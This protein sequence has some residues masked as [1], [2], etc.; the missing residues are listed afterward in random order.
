MKQKLQQYWKDDSGTATIEAVLWVPIFFVIF[1]LIADA[2]FL[3]HHQAN[4][5]RVVHDANRQYSIGRLNTAADAEA[6][7]T[8]R[9]GDAATDPDTVVD[10][11]QS[12]GIIY[13]S[14]QVEVGYFLATG[15]FAP[16]NDV[17]LVVQSQHV[18]EN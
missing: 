5:T 15:L 2:S 7:V 13:T 14:L 12:G 8:A 10:T 17:T 11:W 6:F 18:M 1:C 4:L 9:L 3:F 16:L